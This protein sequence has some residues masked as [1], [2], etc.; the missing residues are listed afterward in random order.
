MAKANKVYYF[1]LLVCTALLTIIH[2]LT[3]TPVNWFTGGL[4]WLYMFLNTLG[5]YLESNN[6]GK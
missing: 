4:L 6:S 5:M 2:F 1:I 3:Q